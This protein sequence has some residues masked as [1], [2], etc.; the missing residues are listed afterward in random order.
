L[1]LRRRLLFGTVGILAL[2]V[3]ESHYRLTFLSDRWVM[4]SWKPSPVYTESPVSILKRHVHVSV[5]RRQR[6]FQR[7]APLD[8]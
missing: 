4:A 2:V 5:K 8:I 7:G 3:L 6:P 1:V